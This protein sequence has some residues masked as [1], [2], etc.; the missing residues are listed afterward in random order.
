MSAPCLTLFTKTGGILSK[1]I[2][3]EGDRVAI[4]GSLCVMADG[5]AQRVNVPDA[6][7]LADLMATMSPQQAIAFGTL[8]H[9][10]D[11]LVKVVP[12]RKLEELN[13]GVSGIIARTQQSIVY[14]PGRAA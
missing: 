8:R 13:G 5:E 10:L 9:G 6:V 4:D 3:L 12:R 1:R 2:S 14:E 11:D 7:A